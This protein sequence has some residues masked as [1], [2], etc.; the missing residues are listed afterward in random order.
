MEIKNP[1]FFKN[2]ESAKKIKRY[3]LIEGTGESCLEGSDIWTTVFDNEEEAVHEADL[4]W[5]HLTPIEKKHGSNIIV[6]VTYGDTDFLKYEIDEENGG[7]VVY[8]D[9]EYTELRNYWNYEN[10]EENE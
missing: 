9:S 4:N 10:E 1:E 2:L 8:W 6:A 7:I 3:L 5:R